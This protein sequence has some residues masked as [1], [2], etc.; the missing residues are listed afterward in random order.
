M[1]KDKMDT[2]CL[3]EGFQRKATKGCILVPFLRTTSA[4]HNETYFQINVCRITG[5][6]S[7]MCKPE[8]SMYKSLEMQDLMQLGLESSRAPPPSIRSWQS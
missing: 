8:L 4:E 5:H 3:D 6:I 1:E 7:Q 2:F